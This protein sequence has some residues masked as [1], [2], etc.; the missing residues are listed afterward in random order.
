MQ[1]T[2]ATKPVKAA[3]NSSTKVSAA[4]RRMLKRK[5]LEKEAKKLDAE[6]R[7]Y[8][9][10]FAKILNPGFIVSIRHNP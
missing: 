9:K 1:D 10:I 3:K 7:K 4:T 8:K 6:L 5:A 2:M